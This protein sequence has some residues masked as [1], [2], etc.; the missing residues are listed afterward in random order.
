MSE[1][2]WSIDGLPWPRLERLTHSRGLEFLHALF[3]ELHH[4]STLH[5]HSE[6]T[7]PAT[8]ST[9]EPNIFPTQIPERPA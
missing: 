9:G 5:K 1:M 7:F 6:E 4:Q 8:L 2:L 3:R